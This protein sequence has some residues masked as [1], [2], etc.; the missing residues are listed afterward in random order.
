ML[1]MFVFNICVFKRTQTVFTVACLQVYFR[2]GQKI[3]YF[4]EDIWGQ[5]PPAPC[6]TVGSTFNTEEQ[7]SPS[8]INVFIRFWHTVLF[9]LIRTVKQLLFLVIF[10]DFRESSQGRNQ[11]FSMKPVYLLLLIFE[12]TI[13][14]FGLY[15]TQILALISII[16]MLCQ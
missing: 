6:R 8:Y 11:N 7:W 4:F 2:E 5:P 13:T 15:I 1:W 12:G 9:E 10:P 16:L 14:M 3:K